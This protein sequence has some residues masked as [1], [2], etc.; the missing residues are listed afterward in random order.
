MTVTVW[1]VRI[2]KMRRSERSKWKR[3]DNPDVWIDQ[4]GDIRDMSSKDPTHYKNG[5]GFRIQDVTQLTTFLP[6]NMAG[7]PY[8]DPHRHYGDNPKYLF[9]DNEEMLVFLNGRIGNLCDKAVL[10]RDDDN[11]SKK[12]KGAK[13]LFET[14]GDNLLFSE[15]QKLFCKKICLFDPIGSHKKCGNHLSLEDI[16][17]VDLLENI[18]GFLEELQLYDEFKERPF[19][20]INIQLLKENSDR[21]SIEKSKNL[22]FGR[23]GQYEVWKFLI[24]LVSLYTCMEETIDNKIGSFTSCTWSEGTLEFKSSEIGK[25][26]G[27]VPPPLSEWGWGPEYYPVDNPCIKNPPCH[28]CEKDFVRDKHIEQ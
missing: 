20:R 19:P 10:Q 24:L 1:P 27:L 22:N 25:Q 12:F 6:R 11:R 17:E 9:I 28:L 16:A 3:M 2:A 26:S 13:S 18:P 21:K 5:E 15:L 14:A 7:V 8:N 4:F 23:E